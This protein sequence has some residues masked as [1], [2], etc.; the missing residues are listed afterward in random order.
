MRE[1]L[2]SID[3]KT[4]VVQHV[5]SEWMREEE[6]RSLQVLSPSIVSK[7]CLQNKSCSACR[8]W[9]NEKV[10]EWE[11]EKMREWLLSIV[12]KT[13]VVHHV[14]RNNERERER[15][16]E[17]E[18]VRERES[19]RVSERVRESVR[20]R[21]REWVRVREN[22]RV[23]E[24]VLSIEMKTKVVQHVKSDSMRDWKSVRVRKSEREWECDL[25]P[26]FCLTFRHFFETL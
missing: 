10:W 23:W 5:K 17:W 15:E 4:K 26:S 22:E 21:E 25:V 24:W 11:S 3:M 8:E 18:R 13:K 16:R 20:E 14:P 19:E 7:Y 9:V 1:C 6:E 2:L 12:M